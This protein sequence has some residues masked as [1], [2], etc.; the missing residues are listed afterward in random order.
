MT[1]LLKSLIESLRLELQQYGGN[2][3]S[4]GP[5]TGTCGRARIG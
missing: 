1:E 2:A 4:A 5:A 3:R